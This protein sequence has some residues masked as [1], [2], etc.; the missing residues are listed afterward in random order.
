M[1]D[2]HFRFHPRYTAGSPG[3]WFGGSRDND[4]LFERL[5]GQEREAHARYLEGVYG[6]AAKAAAEAVGLRGIAET[7]MEAGR[8]KQRGWLIHDL[9]T[10]E[11]Q[12][13]VSGDPMREYEER[14]H[15]IAR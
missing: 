4:R 8:G 10:E 12:H 15:A 14:Q 11:R 1:A 7:R 3:N 5:I 2:V 9:I 6:E 13:I